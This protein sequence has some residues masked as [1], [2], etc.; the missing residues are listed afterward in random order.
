MRR[1]KRGEEKRN[2]IER[3]KSLTV[4]CTT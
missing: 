3:G 4:L 2:L 1:E